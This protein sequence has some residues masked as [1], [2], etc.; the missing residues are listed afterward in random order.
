MKDSHFETMSLPEEMQVYAPDGSE[1]R[2]LLQMKGG[3]MC[4][5]T[6]PPD[7][8]SLA[9]MHQNVEE[10]WY[11]LEGRGQ[12]WRKS[13]HGEEET[14]DVSPG[15]NLSIPPHTHFQF[16]ATGPEPLRF[17]LTTMP[18]WPGE[19]EWIQVAAHWQPSA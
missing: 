13:P 1:I 2:L 8:I 12:V 9:G 19:Q 7:H 17:I 6:L 16:R 5:C 14:V 10:I 11:I 18:P 4:H 15:V 3:S